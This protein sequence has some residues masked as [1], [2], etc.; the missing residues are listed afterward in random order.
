[1][2]EIYDSV[3]NDELQRKSQEIALE[4]ISEHTGL[5]APLDRINID[6]DQIVPKQFLRR[7]E[8]TG[9]GKYLF[10]DWRYLDSEG[11][12]E[13]PEFELNKPHY[14]GA[15]IL[16]TRD[17][18]GCGSSRE[19]A[20]WALWD[21]GFRLIIAPSF[22]DI[23][24]NNCFKNG[25]VPV[26][27]KSSDVDELFAAV[28]QSQGFQLTLDLHLQLILSPVGKKYSFPIDTFGKECLLKGLDSIGWTEQF[29]NKIEAFEQRDKVSRPWLYVA[30]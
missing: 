18:F 20:P 21:Y 29:F 14:K 28:K 6:T 1:M 4:P 30:K 3:N 16:L 7:I 9:Y 27:L 11:T 23:F 8:R 24:Y 25:I 15:T 26:V 2:L 12:K 19:H 13:N 5:V 10:H 17:N 22:A